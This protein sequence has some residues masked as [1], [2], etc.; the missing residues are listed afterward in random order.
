MPCRRK[1]S[2]TL[3]ASASSSPT[4]VPSTSAIHTRTEHLRRLEYH[5]SRGAPNFSQQ[6][7]DRLT[8][9]A[10][11]LDDGRLKRTFSDKIKKLS[12]HVMRYIN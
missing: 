9:R 12:M 1:E 5:A 6:L 11:E 10:Q 7:G 4:L 8:R 2:F 3:E